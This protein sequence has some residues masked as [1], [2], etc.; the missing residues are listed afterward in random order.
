MKYL[1]KVFV[2][3]ICFLAI[4]S[5]SNAG[6]VG[7][8]VVVLFDRPTGSSSEGGP[9]ENALGLSDG[10]SVSI[11]IPETAI[12]AFTDNIAEDGPGNDIRIYENINGDSKADIFASKDNIV[13]TYLGRASG[14]VEYDL[15]DYG[16]DFILY[17]KLVGLDNGGSAAG[18][19]LDAVE[20]L[21]SKYDCCE[22][23]LNQDGKCDMQ[24]WLLFGQDWGRTDCEA[25]LV[26]TWIGEETGGLPGN[27]ASCFQGELL[28]VIGPNEW[29]RGVFSLKKNVIPFQI[30]Y[31]ITECSVPAFVGQTSLGIYQVSGNTLS[32]AF[33]PPGNPSRPTTFTPDG[34]SRVWDLNK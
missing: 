29:Y 18:F 22:C 27:W 7:L 3:L 31:T 11:D 21:N 16:L 25:D 4:G 9:V 17:I 15:A 19:D 6:D 28:H 24:D 13:Y 30:D 5:I 14:N 10:K 20:A 34:T 33:N 32:I 12:F 2:Y 26:S 8:D 23:D 1:T